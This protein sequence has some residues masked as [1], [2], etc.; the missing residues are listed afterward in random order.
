M[1]VF[2]TFTKTVPLK[3]PENDL[4]GEIN[5]YKHQLFN[6][7]LICCHHV[8]LVVVMDNNASIHLM[9]GPVFNQTA[10][11]TEMGE[12]E[13]ERWEDEAV[14]AFSLGFLSKYT[15]IFTRITLN[16]LTPR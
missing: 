10:C 8:L 4:I 15:N 5:P 2:I 9:D 6:I 16:V 3:S 11:Q 12:E 7:D 1:C 13:A 14:L